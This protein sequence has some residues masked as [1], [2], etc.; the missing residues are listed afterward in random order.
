[1]MLNWL[2]QTK[3]KMLF[4]KLIYKIIRIF[5]INPNRIIRRDGIF[6]NLDLREG[7]D[8]SIFLFGNFQKYIYKNLT[9]VIPKNPTIIDVG[10][11]I[12]FISLKLAKIFPQAQ[13]YAFEPTYYAMEKLKK[14]LDLNPILSARVEPIHSF[15]GEQS[16]KRSAYVAFSSWPIDT[17]KG[18][19]NKHEIHLGE[20]KEA[21]LNQISIDDFVKI[22]KIEK[23]D[24]IKIDT[25]G[26]ELNVIKGSMKTLKKD[27]PIVVFEYGNYLLREK[28]IDPLE[29]FQLFQS[30][31]YSLR[32]LKR[33]RII[34]IETIHKIVPPQG[35]IDILAIPMEEDFC[36]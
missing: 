32:D 8:L 20:E 12:G 5:R 34:T 31:G 18:D 7:I 2:Q 3:L 28:G 25:D 36:F 33:H 35:T 4:A 15:V 22:N 30:I 17:F 21:T 11:N 9:T 27:R 24:L 19:K 26:Y 1:M 10:A 16:S 13:V 23:I 14:N 6:Y 29:Y